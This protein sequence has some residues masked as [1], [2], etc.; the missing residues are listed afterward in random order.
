[1][2]VTS[3]AKALGV[4]PK[5]LFR[6]LAMHEWIYRR[7][8]GKGWLAY[9]LRIA[10]GVLEHKVTTLVRD[11]GLEKIVEQALVTPKG[12]ALLAERVETQI[13]S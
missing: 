2:N 13:L 7:A 4:G 6:W 5:A 9:Q 3:A 10:Q 11:D 8:G 1:M 12:L